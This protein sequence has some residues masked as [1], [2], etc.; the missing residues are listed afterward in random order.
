MLINLKEIQCNSFKCD[1][2]TAD[3]VH[4]AMLMS[5]EVEKSQEFQTGI[6]S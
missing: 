5:C 3:A 4:T 1:F 6:P 2:F